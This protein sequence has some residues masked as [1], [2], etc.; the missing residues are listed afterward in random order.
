[1][2]AKK[3]TRR[4]AAERPG[5]RTRE[6]FRR[7]NQAMQVWKPLRV[8]HTRT[9]SRGDENL[10]TSNL[11]EN[12]SHEWMRKPG[13]SSRT[14]LLIALAHD[15]GAIV[16]LATRISSE[17]WVS[18]FHTPVVWVR[19][20][21]AGISLAVVARQNGDLLSKQEY[22]FPIGFGQSAC[23][24]G[25]MLRLLR[26][27]AALARGNGKLPIFLKGKLNLFTFRNVHGRRQVSR[28]VSC[29]SNNTM[30]MSSI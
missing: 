2:K 11:T 25:R 13:R 4:V 18:Y 24:T 5:Y 9:A 8:S 7:S 14:A 19:S 28:H 30:V 26:L 27:L 1:L 17:A 12:P 23:K 16:S 6:E 15:S 20:Q 29:W 22:E 10:S 21:N 3:G